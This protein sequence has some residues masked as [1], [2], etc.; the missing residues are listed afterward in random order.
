MANVVTIDLI[1]S[2]RRIDVV[3]IDVEGHEEKVLRGGE[4]I[5]HTQSLRPRAIFLEVEPCAWAS[6]G[7]TSDTFLRIFARAGYRLSHT[8]ERLSLD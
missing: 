1:L 5:L 8:A 6:H 3:K 4:E 2:G 7:V